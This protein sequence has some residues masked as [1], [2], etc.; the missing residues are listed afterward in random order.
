MKNKLV[1][2]VVLVLLL[3]VLP[4]Y[5]CA[6]EVAGRA[7]KRVVLW[8]DTTPFLPHNDLV[9]NLRRGDTVVFG[10]GTEVELGQREYGNPADDYGA[11]FKVGD[12]AAIWIPF[13]TA[14]PRKLEGFRRDQPRLLSFT[15]DF[16]KLSSKLSEYGIA[17]RKIRL[18]GYEDQYFLIDEMPKGAFSLQ[19]YLTPGTIGPAAL[20]KAARRLADTRLRQFTEAAAPFRQIGL[21]DGTRNLY[22]APEQGWFLR[23][24]T[25]YNEMV[26]EDDLLSPTPF[27]F[28]GEFSSQFRF[29]REGYEAE[30]AERAGRTYPGRSLI[31]NPE[32][33]SLFL[34]LE[35]TTRVA[36]RHLFG[37]ENTV[38]WE[39]SR[40]LDD[41]LP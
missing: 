38:S 1:G 4:A 31:L 28:S 3:P 12:G 32:A 23:E 24:F 26:G 21:D 20:D 17:R 10:D 39:R 34:K 33:R 5:P 18:R 13:F 36:R 35:E 37:K 9:K 30:M 14:N 40:P 7:S 6:K 27:I 11:S 29:T 8:R 19:A 16:V 22:Y 25:A 15:T 2:L 41:V